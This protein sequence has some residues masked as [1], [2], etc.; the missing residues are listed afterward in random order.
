MDDSTNHP[1]LDTLATYALGA[2]PDDEA[3]GIGQHL[4]TCVQCQREAQSLGLTADLVPY[5]IML[6]EP[7]ASLRERV[8]A[9]ALASQP[10]SRSQDELPAARGRAAPQLA[11]APIP[12]RRGRTLVLRS[13]ALAAMLVIGLLIGRAIPSQQSTNI[14]HEQG[15]H[16]TALAGQGNG[17]FVIVP[18]S[19]RAELSVEGLP[20]L[21]GGR[22]YQLWLIG[23]GAPI[24]S[25]TFTVDASGRGHLQI[26][27]LAWSSTYQVIA[28]TAEPT[29]GSPSPT[30]DIIIK[31]NVPA[32]DT[33]NS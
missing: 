3:V 29:G 14:A 13:L 19:G 23:S 33:P 32:G 26:D 17:S 12:I 25:G 10:S 20:T 27:G 24:A 28:I 30:S 8:L 21:T 11:S 18:A 4:A 22:V 16:S 5:G 2:L 1:D 9:Q 7:P 15:A 6:V 31:G